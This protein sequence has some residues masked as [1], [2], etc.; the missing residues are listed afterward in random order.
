LD[1]EIALIGAEDVKDSELLVK[2]GRV[3]QTF[4]ESSL[5]IL[6]EGLSVLLGCHNTVPE[7]GSLNN[8]N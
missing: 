4:L 1:F 8:R 6:A 7:S 3:P 5:A 2:R